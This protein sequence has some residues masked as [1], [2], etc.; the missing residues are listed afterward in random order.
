MPPRSAS[1]AG[2]R[3]RRPQRT[4]ATTRGRR[5]IARARSGTL[6]CG[7]SRHERLR[8]RRPPRTSNCRQGCC[9]RRSLWRRCPTP[10]DKPTGGLRPCWREVWR[11]A[12]RARGAPAHAGRARMPPAPAR[13][14]LRSRARAGQPPR[15]LRPRPRRASSTRATRSASGLCPPRRRAAWRALLRRASVL[16]AS[17]PRPQPWRVRRRR[18]ARP[19]SLTEAPRPW[20]NAPPPLGTACSTPTPSGGPRPRPLWPQQAARAE[21]RSSG[22]GHRRHA[23]P[24]AASTQAAC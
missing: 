2:N 20:R 1:S 18:H 12:S 14:P 3:R 11:P 19:E 24:G 7:G 10:C 8:L 9:S 17:S 13:P 4:E 21:P 22:E 5:S 6:T 16:T 23:R 15:S